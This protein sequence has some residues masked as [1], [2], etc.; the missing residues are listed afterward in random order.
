M[1]RSW[2]RL[3][4]TLS[5]CIFVFFGCQSSDDDDNDDANNDD[6]AADDDTADDNN[7][8]PFD[9]I[10]V[11]WETCSLFEGLNDGRAEC[12]AVE[13]PFD[14]FE[15][16]E[17]TFTVGVKR[18]LSNHQPSEAQLWLLHGGPGGSGTIGLTYFM[19]S[20]QGL[21]PEL[22]VYTLDPRGAGY[23][24]YLGCPDQEDAHSSNGDYIDSGELDDCIEYLTQTYG[25]DLAVFNTTNPAIDLAALIDRTREENKRVIV[26]GGSGGTFWGQRYLQFFPDQA[27]GMVFEGNVPPAFSLVFQDEYA[28]FATSEILRLCSE[29]AFCSAKLPD[30]EGTMRELWRKMDEEN[31]CAETGYTSLLTKQV[32]DQLVYYWPYHDMVPALIYRLDR[33]NADDAEAVVNLFYAI[34]GGGKGAGVKADDWSIDQLS[35]SDVLFFN[36]TFSELWDYPEFSSNDDLLAYLDEVYLD[37]LIG[38]G[39]GYD[40]NDYYLEWPRYTDPYDDTWPVTNVPMLVLQGRL[41]PATP[42]DLAL[43]LRDNY[44]APHQHFVEFAY[45]AHNVTGGTPL[46]NDENAEHCSDRLFVD[47]MRDPQAELDLLCVDQVMPPDFEGLA[48]APYFFGTP[49]YWENPTNR[50]G[51]ASNLP[52]LPPQL[53]QIQ[54]EIEHGFWAR[55][56]LRASN[57]Q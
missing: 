7:G 32:I 56:S 30:P 50:S 14:W 22:D 25:D 8:F 43:E 1:L 5:L 12:A 29:D 23:S 47:F 17:K 13:M 51:P 48:Y 31:H 53:R 4:C 18:L 54:R 34:F 2:L 40:R 33:C 41:D 44:T 3:F 24:E 27:D 15:P 46:S 9:D 19:D 11:S 39:K 26:W 49:D 57:K 55:Y 37:T 52:S 16:G 45:A 20:I 38:Y 6:D 21:Y 36:E 35:F 28:D 10:V 42:Y